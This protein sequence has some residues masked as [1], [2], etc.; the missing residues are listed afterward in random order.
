MLDFL[1]DIK[2]D[3][4]EIKKGAGGGHRKAWTPTVPLAIRLWK[5]GSVYPSQ[6]LVERFDLEYH[7]KPADDDKTPT[8]G[9]AFDVFE[10]AHFP[11]FNT[12]KPVV[13]I[14]VTS[15]ALGKADL[16]ARTDWTEEGKPTFSVMEQGSNSF[17]KI[18]KDPKEGKGLLQM[19]EDT[20]GVVP[21]ETGFID[22]VIIG[23]DGEA[24]KTAFALPSGKTICYVPKE[25]ARGER[26]GEMSVVRRENP[27]LYILYPYDLIHPPVT[28]EKK[29][30]AKS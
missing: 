5:D 6:D 14:N 23:Q 25:V 2:V 18:R 8:L 1:N 7:D 26:K 24:A 10:S 21:N 16:F 29:A 19:I 22:L 27:W 9:S 4:P 20:Y 12:P 28:E 17:G 3:A 11:I 30:D 15:R 13:L